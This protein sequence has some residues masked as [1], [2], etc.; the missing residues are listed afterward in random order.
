MSLTRE[1]LNT[2][3]INP[4]HL[5]YRLGV[6]MMIINNK[7]E[8][9]LARRIDTKWEAWQMP[10]GGI[11]TGET[12]SAAAMREMAEEIGCSKGTILAES[13]YWYSYDIPKQLL[14]KLWDGNFRGQK[15]KWFLIRFD[16]VDSE[17]NLDTHDP[18][19][20]SWKWAALDEVID[21]IVPFKR[22][23]YNAVIKEF[24]H[25]ITK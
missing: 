21:I 1:N 8:V 25:L 11:D 19:F 14:P 17:I 9:F 20:D 6:G 16:G 15:Q 22:K 13:K 12:P 7:K 2:T 24:Y 10:Q 3:I 23:L 5:P 18:E 4:S